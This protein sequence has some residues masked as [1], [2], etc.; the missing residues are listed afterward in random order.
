MQSLTIIPTNLATLVL[1]SFLYGL[2]MLLYFDSPLF[3]N[4]TSP[5]GQDHQ[6]SSHFSCVSWSYRSFPNCNGAFFAFIHLGNAVSEDVFYADL[7]QPSEVAKI[8][9]F[10]IA[11]LLGDSLV[12]YRLWIIWGRNM[13]VIIFPIFALVGIFI[14]AV[15]LTIK[16]WA[17]KPSLRGAPFD[18]ESRP[19]ELAGPR[20]SLLRGQTDGELIQWFLVIL[21][22]SAALQTFWLIIKRISNTLIHARVGLGW[23]EHSVEVQKQRSAEESPGNAVCLIKEAA[24][25]YVHV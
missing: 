20:L 23:S 14:S 1:E 11:I 17:W 16:I 6:T 24:G 21:V 8:F 15:A 18:S 3:D 19:W 13:K 25:T 2:L 22:K 9:F 4:A 10:F 7:V 5:C 12:A